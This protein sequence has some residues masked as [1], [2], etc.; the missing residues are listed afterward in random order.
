M[1]PSQHKR[2]EWKLTER[3][4]RLGRELYI[5]EFGYGP[6]EKDT[7]ENNLT[8][9]TIEK[10]KYQDEEELFPEGKLKFELHLKKERSNKLIALKK[11][12]EFDK[13]P[14]LPCEICGISLKKNMVK[15]E[16]GLSKHTTFFQFPN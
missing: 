12:L 14:L 8:N 15:L 4:A 7:N 3:G 2:N 11:K 6:D 9:N 13:N 16:K 1:S 5:K 10:F